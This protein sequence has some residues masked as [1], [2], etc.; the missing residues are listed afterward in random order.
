MNTYNKLQKFFS[1]IKQFEND[2]KFLS[3]KGPSSITVFIENFASQLLEIYFGYEFYN[4]NY[5]RHNMSGIDLLNQDQTHG[6]QVTIER[7][8]SRKVNNT[9]NKSNNIK[10][11]TVFFFNH[12]K[13]D[14][15][16]KNLTD[17]GYK[18]DDVEIISLYHIFIDAE[19]NPIK[20]DKYY[21]V[22][23]LWID[24]NS[25]YNNMVEIFNEKVLNKI[26]ANKLSKKYIPDIY[27]PENILRKEARVFAEPAFFIDML[28]YYSKAFFKGSIY[29][30]VKDKKALINGNKELNFYQ[31]CNVEEE[32]KSGNILDIKSIVKKLYNYCDFLKGDYWGVKYL[33]KSGTPIGFNEVYSNINSS[34]HFSVE[35]LLELYELSRKQY[36]F[37][38]KD[39]G[40]G[41]TNFLCNLCEKVLLKRSIPVIYINVNELTNNLLDSIKEQIQNCCNKDY[42]SALQFLKQY[43][44]S[45]Q[46]KIIIVIDGLNEKNNLPAFKKEVLELFRF[47]EGN[48]LFKV[49]ATSRYVAYE[50][51]YKSFNNESFGNKIYSSIERNSQRKGIDFQKKL[52]YKYKNYFK[53]TCYVSNIAKNKL[54]N[55]ILL[56]RIFSE[57]Y[58][59]NST[60]VVNDIFL[61]KIFYNYIEKRATQLEIDGRIKRKDDLF[62]LLRKIAKLMANTKELN[63]FSN[64][65]FSS[66]ERD[67]LDTIVNED[68][69]IKTCENDPQMLQLP[70]TKFSFTYDEFRDYLIAIY[71]TST[72]NDDFAK[73]YHYMAL[74]KERYDGVLKYLFLILKSKP[75][76]KLEIMKG[77]KIYAQ[78]YGSNI[79]SIEDN[80]LKNEDI[81]I[82]EKAIKN[83][84]KWAFSNI[85]N[86]LD[87]EHY[88]NISILNL[89]NYRYKEFNG[90]NEEWKQL[91][92]L[93]NSM[94]EYTG[95]IPNLLK[96]KCE[97]IV[98]SE[99]F[100]LLAFLSSFEAW[101]C[102]D[103]IKVI[104]LIWQKY[105]L[106]CQN[107]IVKIREEFPKFINK[108]NLICEVSQ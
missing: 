32:L 85:C 74:N 27:I 93:K 16:I 39:A 99:I 104:K 36:F 102:A 70:K 92:I 45:I 40:Q 51:F 83:S 12:Q 56:L 94:G 20:L 55:D 71:F 47:I 97:D 77:E 79:F 106:T 88:K 75:N 107:A 33:N 9:I 28:Y 21:Y 90:N 91:F 3:T 2:I 57:V 69:I 17:K 105:K 44:K 66:E 78:I 61:Y 7:N 29:N 80:L 41:K 89:V 37:I 95:I 108:I 15:I 30:Y 38:I 63:N 34:L 73:E 103:E 82:I 14:R 100:G 62:E 18:L 26:N 46:R 96:N 24:G 64:S 65:E 68:I 87:C 35:K 101:I 50:T 72:E 25:H 23:K 98:E 43:C 76:D 8:N 54:A 81:E 59:N 6:I 19:K 1:L 13:T 22:S 31:D 60:S 5:I 58:Q 49:I 84:N 53:F 67:L 10:K 52:Y 11:L 86:R 48:D 42:I 4:V